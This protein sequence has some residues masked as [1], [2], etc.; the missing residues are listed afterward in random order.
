MKKYRIL[1][2]IWNEFFVE[3][4]RWW[5]WKRFAY[6]FETE[7]QA[8]KFIRKEKISQIG[9]PWIVKEVNIII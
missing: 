2:N 6:T 4:K 9:C 3:K 8:E 7:Q 1:T 5:G